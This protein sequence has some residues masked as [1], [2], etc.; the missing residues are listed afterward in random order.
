MLCTVNTF[1]EDEFP[2]ASVDII[3]ALQQI[4]MKRVAVD[5]K[6]TVVTDKCWLAASQPFAP[7]TQF[8]EFLLKCSNIDLSP[9]CYIEHKTHTMTIYLQNKIWSFYQAYKINFPQQIC[10][11]HATVLIEWRPRK[12]FPAE[13]K[14]YLK[15]APFRMWPRPFTNTVAGIVAIPIWWIVSRYSSIA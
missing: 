11:H 10:Q 15:T 9:V 13:R 12:L 7:V 14:W 3:E 8:T 4:I 2:G 6:Q 1:I 5:N